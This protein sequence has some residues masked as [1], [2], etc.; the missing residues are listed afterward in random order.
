MK[1]MRVPQKLLSALLTALLPAAGVCA[2]EVQPFAIY[3]QS[4]VLQVYGLPLPRGFRVLPEAAQELDF[5]LDLTN[6][7]ESQTGPSESLVFDGET[8]RGTLIYR[9]GFAGNMEFSA[10]LP[11]IKQDGGFMD[12]FIDDFHDVFGFGSGGRARAAEDQLLYRVIHNGSTLLNM[13]DSADGVGDLRLS[14]QRQLTGLPENRGA[15]IGATLKLPVGDADDLT[16]SEA[17]DLALWATYGTADA[18][19]PWGLLGSLGAIYTGA[20]EVLREL[21]RQGAVFATLT[22]GY[23]WNEQLQFKAQIYAHSALYKST[24]LEAL[25]GAPVQGALGGSWQFLPQWGL[26]VAVVEDLNVGASPDASFHFALKR[27]F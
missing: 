3:N 8:H 14:L 26:D 5:T 25:D 17:A 16:G 12:G 7:F 19:S 23:A 24:Q 15:A 9:R 18:A 21:R 13:V 20:G 6:N 27:R 2:A 22:L 11:F 4:P 10:E 1:T